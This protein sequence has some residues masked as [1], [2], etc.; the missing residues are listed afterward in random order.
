MLVAI[1]R[2]LLTPSKTMKLFLM[3]KK[4]RFIQAGHPHHVFRDRHSSQYPTHCL[5]VMGC[6]LLAVLLNFTACTKH[7]GYDAILD[8][9][10]S[11]V[12][13][14]PDSVI[15]LLEPLTPEK[16]NMETSQQ[17]RWQLLLTAAQNKCDSVFGDD[18]LQL[19]LV[20]YYDHH[21]TPNERMSAHY[22]LGRAY[23]DMGEAPRALQ[24]FLDA[25]AC[26]D[27]TS[28]DCDYQNLFRIYGQIANIY[29]SQCMPNEELAAWNQ[30]SHYALK[31]GDLYY[32]I[33]G[34]EMTIGPYY[35]MGDTVSCLHITEQCRQ[36]YKRHGM[37]QEAASVFPSAIYIHLLNSNFV[38]AREMMQTFESESGLFDSKGNIRKGR[39]S[40]YYSKGL[41]YLGVQK[42]DS[43]EYY[44]RKLQNVHFNHDY[45]ANK[46][47]LSLYRKRNAIDSISKYATLYEK[48]VD[49]ILNDNQSEAIAITSSLYNY[50]RIE[51]IAKQKTLELERR[52]VWF[53]LVSLLCLLTI[54]S[55]II[56]FLR[57]K[58]KKEA[59]LGRLSS[60][61]M[62][63]IR[64][65]ESL[66]QELLVLEQDSTSI[67]EDK[68]REIAKL[69]EMIAEYKARFSR[70]PDEK[71][72]AAMLND[73]IVL[74][75]REK[76]K[77]KKGVALPTSSDWS[78]LKALLQ[79]NNPQFYEKVVNGALT[80]QELQT[81]ILCRLDFHTGEIA[82][83]LDTTSQSITNAKISANQK[84]FG[85][86]NASSLK[87]NLKRI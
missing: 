67:I 71:W 65:Y 26:A 61:R 15:Q 33:S 53:W 70:L 57:Q 68:K 84:L 42:N 58:R 6:L 64:R 9:A 82:V 60:E 43:A 23:S 21:G 63:A 13:V 24:C 56:M 40:Y 59:E 44:F 29:R 27:T 81:C 12:N 83:L 30:F 37:H 75:F 10:D 41:Y 49:E 32:Y 3:A 14:H 80:E 7:R 54:I 34:I 25:V 35:D 52:K 1:G 46:G 20:D 31:S 76:A 38:K 79:E 62:A 66:E 2:W 18:S 47:L 4:D 86:K 74:S 72:E 87:A 11:L 17:M 16:K 85:V 78:L 51:Q 22:L 77:A 19:E 69:S 28:R 8:T 48:S 73:V 5:F 55:G 45:Q 36:E 50:N 39:E